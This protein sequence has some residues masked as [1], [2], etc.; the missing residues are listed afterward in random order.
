MKFDEIYERLSTY[1]TSDGEKL[2]FLL[3]PTTMRG[4]Y[5]C[6]LHNNAQECIELGTG[7]GATT[8]IIAAALQERG[9]GCITTVDT[10]VHDP[11]GIHI[12]AA[13]TG[14]TPYINAICSTAGY[15]WYMGDLIAAQTKDGACEPCLDFCFLDGAH[16]WGHDALAVYLAGKLL[17][18][19][20]W[21][22]MDDLDLRPR[23]GHPAWETVFAH[24]TE[25]E[26]DTYH[27]ARVYNLIL[28]QHPDF[29]EFALSDGGRTG[30]ARK[31][32][33]A[34]SSWYPT[35]HVLEPP[36]LDWRQAFAPAELVAQSHLTDG[37]KIQRKGNAIQIDAALSD[38]F[39]ILPGAVVAHGSVD[40][41]TLR[42]R[43]VSPPTETLQ[44]F[45]IDAVRENFNEAQSMR[46]KLAAEDGW[47][48]IAIRINGTRE[49]WPLRAI[50]LDLTDGPSTM[51]WDEFVIG[52]W[53]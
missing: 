15:N 43:L 8:C 14:M 21:L 32:S 4:V 29:G 26:L 28:R 47:R 44:I 19:G 35:T 7:Y 52:G 45:W 37:I 1:R 17:R 27:V 48:D 23:G 22:V 40:A 6:V 36:R 46:V 13:H 9:G 42:V 18:P 30:W 39:F 33:A 41:I 49:K 34:P 38:P 24:F 3:T 51:L 53:I 31:K 12:L 11:I 2:L 25:A 10:M 5:D 50:R 20:S 16:E